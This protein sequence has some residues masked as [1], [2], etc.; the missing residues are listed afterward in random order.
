MLGRCLCGGVQFEVVEPAT[1]IGMCHCSKCRR[2]SGV[3]SNAEF[4][5]ARDKL[6][7]VAG[8][9]DIK[10]FALPDGWGTAF[11]STCG[12][13]LPKLHPGGGAYWVPAGLIDDPIDLA[14]AGHI[15]V[16]SKAPW[17]EIAGDAP[18]FEAGFDSRKV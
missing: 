1:P 18:R 15:F 3:A 9:Q 14:V 8:E 13:P 5:V 4:M 12:S 2:V 10:R 17:D 16:G 7:W 11:C 6:R